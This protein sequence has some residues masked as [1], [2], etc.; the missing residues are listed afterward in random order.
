[1]KLKEILSPSFRDYGVSLP[2]GK[3]AVVDLW[4]RCWSVESQFCKA[5]V[6]CGYLSYE[7]MVSAAFRYRL[8]A[9]KNGGVIFWQ[10]DNEE[11]IHDGKVVYYNPD[12]HRSKQKELHPTWVSTLLKR[13][14]DSLPNDHTSHCLFGLHLI[15]DQAGPLRV[16]AYQNE[17]A[18]GGAVKPLPWRGQRGLGFRSKPSLGQGGLGSCDPAGEPCITTICIVEAEKTAVI[19][20]ELYPDYLWLASGGLGELQPYKFRPLR[21]RKVVLFPDTDSDGHT[22]KRWSDMAQEVMHADFWDDSPPITVSRL[23]EQRATPEQKARKI[24]LV[25]LK[26]ENTERL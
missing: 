7:Q 22:F 14:M 17:R 6:N 10:I 18:T 19:L 12:C 9:S 26:F 15:K 25:D 3:P 5:V 21:G 8:G 16:P 23:L 13:R 20:S 1:M 4:Q 11:R 2:T 24:D